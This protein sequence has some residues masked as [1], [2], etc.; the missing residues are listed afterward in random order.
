[1]SSG[2]EYTTDS[3][4]EA[5]GRDQLE[6]WVARFLSSPGSDNGG[7]AHL[8]TAERPLAWLGPVQLPLDQLHRLAGPPDQPVLT[9]VED[10]EWRD[11]VDDLARR[12][13]EGHEPAPVI[14]SHQGDHLRLEDGNHRVEALRRAGIDQAWAVIGFEDPDERERFVARSEAVDRT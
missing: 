8:L 11:D 4:R 13:E 9:P 5:A 7:L 1:M 14:V 2:Q 12:I 6:D 10:H 3:A